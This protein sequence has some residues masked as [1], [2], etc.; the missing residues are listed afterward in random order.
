MAEY[1][2]L[3]GPDG[4]VWGFWFRSQPEQ[5]T[6]RMIA[7]QK[8]LS[9]EVYQDILTQNYRIVPNTYDNNGGFWVMFGSRLAPGEKSSSKQKVE[10]PRK[11]WQF[12]RVTKSTGSESSEEQTM[13][14][15]LIVK[16]K[17]K[18]P[19]KRV[20]KST[21][22]ES[23]E[24]QTMT[25]TLIFSLKA[26]LGQAE[27]VLSAIDTIK[28]KHGVSIVDHK[29]ER[30]QDGF[31]VTFHVKCRN[32]KDALSLEKQFRAIFIQHGILWG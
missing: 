1:A 3:D 27:S 4:K 5:S 19:R 14:E 30:C 8:K 17:V 10:Q 15:P 7:T 11:W 25:G 16:Q 26:R 6:M 31:V 9:D 20:T 22:S 23:P 2:I 24:E 18:Q 13:T 29:T 12:W 28:T 32:E 21:G